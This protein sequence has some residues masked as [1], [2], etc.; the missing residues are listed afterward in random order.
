MEDPDSIYNCYLY[1]LK[2]CSAYIIIDILIFQSRFHLTDPVG[3]VGSVY[4]AGKDA[5]VKGTGSVPTAA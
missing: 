3:R 2:K 4:Q 5:S 1:V